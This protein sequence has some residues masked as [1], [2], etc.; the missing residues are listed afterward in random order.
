VDVR[1]L[2]ALSRA[3]FEALGALLQGNEQ[4]KAELFKPPAGGHAISEA[5]KAEEA[6]KS[7][8]RDKEHAA[9]LT[10]TFNAQDV[11]GTGS[12]S[13]NQIQRFIQGDR[14]HSP[15]GHLVTPDELR[16]IREL[17]TEADDG[18]PDV[19]GVDKR[20]F[21]VLVARLAGEQLVCRHYPHHMPNVHTKCTA[22]PHQTY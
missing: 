7:E 19:Y 15:A 18:S 20:G 14:K 2:T 6:A 10:D 21:A 4:L 8:L 1:H 3:R 17:W 22:H 11:H 5:E 13:F 9:N 16:R 12:I